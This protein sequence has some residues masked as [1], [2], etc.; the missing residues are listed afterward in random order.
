MA[1]ISRGVKKEYVEEVN[2]DGVATQKEMD[3]TFAEH[4]ANYHTEEGLLPAPEEENMILKS[5]TNDDDEIKWKVVKA[6]D[7]QEGLTVIALPYYWDEDREKYLDNQVVRIVM[8]K[9]GDT[10]DEW[11]YYIPNVRSD[12]V[13]YKL[14]E[15][16]TMCIVGYEMSMSEAAN[17]EV[18]EIRNITGYEE[19][20]FGSK[21]AEYDT[22]HVIDLGDDDVD[23]KND[24]T[25]NIDV[26]AGFLL[27]AYVLEDAD[28][29]D[30]VISILMRKVWEVDDD[31]S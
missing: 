14:F 18:A 6:D 8:Y 15:G 22:L 16:E 19:G 3:D 23:T 4:I 24:M 21:T 13:P 17:G 10:D 27:S 29:E 11:I 31:D 28:L 26:E 20:L 12:R 9:D 5:Y 7:P 1:V 30:P 2:L 25:L